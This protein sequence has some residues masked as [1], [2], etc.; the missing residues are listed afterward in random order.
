MAPPRRPGR[1]PERV[2]LQVYALMAALA[3]TL[4]STASADVEGPREYEGPTELG[5][6]GSPGGDVDPP[7]EAPVGVPPPAD[8]SPPDE[9]S[10]PAEAPPAATPPKSE[11]PKPPAPAEEEACDDGFCV[12]DLTEDPEALKRELEVPKVEVKGPTGAVKGRLLDSTNGTPLI[13]A[14]VSAE[15]TDFATKTDFDGNYELPLPPGNYQI[16]IWYDTYEGVTVSN[17]GVAQDDAVT[18]NRELTPIAGMAQTVVVE[19]E[20][21]KESAA[22]KM[23]ERKKS[24]STRDFM[25]RDDINRSGGGATATAAQRI[26]GATVIDNRY[27]FVRGLGHRYGNTLFDGARMP[28]PDPNLRSVPLDIFPSNALAAINIQ[29]TATPDRPADFAGGSV[30]LESREAPDRWTVQLRAMLGLNTATLG[31]ESVYGD[32]FAG[33]GFAFGNVGRDLPGAFDTKYPVDLTQQDANLKRVWTNADIERFG[34]SLPSTKTAIHKGTG[35]PNFG[36]NLTFG[37]TFKPWGTELGFLGA[38]QYNNSTQTL[39]EDIK[40]YNGVD[41]G[42]DLLALNLASPRVDYKSLQTRY[43]VQWSALG[44][45][46]WKLTKHHKMSVEGI[47]TRDATTE[48][49]QLDG[50]SRPTAGEQELRNTRLRYTMRSI[51][52]TRVGGHHE[53]PAAKGLSADWFGSFAQARQ[54]DPLLREMLFV[55][56]GDGYVVDQRESGKFQFFNLVD[57]TGTGAF[58][59]TAPFKQWRQLDSKVK[60]GAW[61]EGKHRDFTTRSFDFQV[62]NGLLGSIPTGTGDILNPDTIGGGVNAMNGGTQP[63]YLQEITRPKDSYSADQQIWAGYAMLDLPLVRW[64]RLVGGARFESSDIKVRPFNPFGQA[65]DDAD[66]AD[67]IDRNVLPSVALI[68]PVGNDKVG[69]MNVRLV[70]TKTLA[71]PEFRELAPFLFTDFVGGFDVYGNPNLRTTKIWNADLRWEWFPSANEV[72]AVSAFYKYF[73]G[74]IER[75]IGA[76]AT[77]VQSYRNALA[78]NNLGAELELRKN[79]SFIHRALRDISLGANFAYIYSRVVFPEITDDT[80]DP[81]AVRTA[82]N[83]PMEGQSPFV[84]N[85]YLAYDNE[86]SG[87]NARLLYNTFGRRIAFVGGQGLP[88]IY[89]L[90]VHSV[91]FSLIQ[92]LHKGL[93]MSFQGMNLLNFQ[94]RFAQG[95]ENAIT[96]SA[97]QGVTFVVG[98]RYDL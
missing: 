25:S 58:D 48:V 6:S 61:G 33:D 29:K 64:F 13:G 41:D 12:E 82:T 73:D 31:R 83:R 70:G 28:S 78:A 50:R 22:G 3:L 55:K 68:F 93:G 81:F 42:G 80:T 23:A 95:D 8:A 39:R 37:N 52:F 53:F 36:G 1:A 75:V 32:H 15:G 46:K 66:K 54:D 17:V 74:P 26:V 94:R 56:S 76:R 49:R 71:R 97:R 79:F 40:V 86:K 65:I 7:S 87:T 89:E 16:K 59:I 5:P 62:A 30:Q 24:A 19:A 91:D 11:A 77:P 84:V 43:N 69:D 20:I 10:P 88:N 35:M 67:V 92:R 38:I 47:Y 45:V 18:L 44:L 34:E 60:F 98:L 21:N 85:T 27:I 9:A 4:P 63:F 72:I 2:D 57:N 51:A 90:P 96:R 14:K